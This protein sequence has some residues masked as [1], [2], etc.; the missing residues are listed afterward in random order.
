MR[1]TGAA[2]GP[3]RKGE[4]SLIP[5]RDIGR[6][7]YGLSCRK[8]IRSGSGVLDFGGKPTNGGVV[9]AEDFDDKNVVFV[10]AIIGGVVFLLGFLGVVIKI[11]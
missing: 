8:P 10:A 4:L 3:R 9:M 5:R 11:L 1:R 6:R 2:A 7:Y